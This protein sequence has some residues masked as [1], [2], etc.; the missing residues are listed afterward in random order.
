VL[1]GVFLIPSG[2]KPSSVKNF[3]N[4]DNN[5]LFS[6]NLDAVKGFLWV[7]LKFAEKN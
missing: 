6:I 4:P 3:T 1:S 2:P 7:N 5:G